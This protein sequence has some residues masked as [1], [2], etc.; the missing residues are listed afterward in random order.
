VLQALYNLSDEQADFMIRDRLSFL[1]FLG[2][3]LADKVPDARTIWL[4]RERLK[5]SGAIEALFARFDDALHD[6][7]FLAKGG[8]LLDATIIEAPRQRLDKHEREAVKAGKTPE[9]WSPKKA[10][11][12]DIQA[13]WTLKRG[14]V[15]TSPDGQIQPQLMVP[16][17][18][19]KAHTSIDKAGGLIRK[20]SV[21][22]ASAYD[23]AQLPNLIDRRNTASPV[24]A[25]T[26]YRSAKNEA[27]LADCGKVSKIHYRRARG[28]PLDKIRAKANA[29]RS[30]DRAAIEHVFAHQKERMR[31]FIRTVGIERARIKIGMA[32][33]AYNMT[34][35]IFLHRKYSLA[36]G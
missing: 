23:G 8:Q 5:R 6:R 27:Y 7:G 24:W 19:Y 35:L 16:A 4:Y 36:T 3:G 25:D 9:G 29:A 32:N 18:G 33:I 17:F 15:T 12:K 30:K 28:K 11:H 10:A 20:W 31:L 14:K 1:R 26:A 22:P 21:T 2:L 13:R 34:R